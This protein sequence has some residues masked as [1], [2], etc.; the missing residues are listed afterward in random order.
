MKIAS[1]KD[2]KSTSKE[3]MKLSTESLITV[4]EL[5]NEIE[6]VN[7]LSFLND[8]CE[9]NTFAKVIEASKSKK[10]DDEEDDDDDDG[11]N[12]DEKDDWEKVEEEEE[13]DPDF[14]EFDIPK[15]GKKAAGKKDK[16]EDVDFDDD[17]KDMDLFNDDD[18]NFD[19]NDDDDF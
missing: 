7:A 16:D 4:D 8:E 17:F 11:S 18:D 5:I 9:L 19:D 1:D 15:S 10:K 6:Q 2:F 12:E 13:W 3:Q 14:E